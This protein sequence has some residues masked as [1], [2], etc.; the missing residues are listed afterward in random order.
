MKSNHP[1]PK[2]GKRKYVESYD[3]KQPK[4]FSKE[5]MRTLRALHDV[6]A[7]NLSRVFSNALRHKVEVHLQKIEQIATS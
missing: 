6:L 7:R 5:I 2:T 3:F 1:V 4:L